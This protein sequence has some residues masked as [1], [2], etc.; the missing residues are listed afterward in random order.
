[1]REHRR[2]AVDR[3][4]AD[5]EPIAAEADGPISTRRWAWEWIKSFLVALGLFLIIR[6]FLV[7]AFRIPT[8]SMENTLL[9]GDFL[10]VNK[11]VYG[12]TVP[13][14]GSRLPGFRDPERGDVVVFVPPHERRRN[15]VK[16]LVGL[17]GDTLLMQNKQ[18]FVNGV[19]FHEP[20]ARHSD[21]NDIYASGMYWQCTYTD[22]RTDDDSCRPTRDNWGP[23]VVPAGRYFMLGDNRDDSEDS[24]YWGFVERAAIRGRPL[25]VYYS[26]DPRAPRAAPWLTSIRWDRL[27][28]TVH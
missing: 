18:L 20:F 5:R 7:E 22:L 27:G 26:F 12:A 9:V 6:T 4:S 16:R 28:R 19:S 8:G 15:Y 21:P 14:A 25:F 23:I 1:M 11:A 24:R 2:S 17:P 13:I 3:A 10:L